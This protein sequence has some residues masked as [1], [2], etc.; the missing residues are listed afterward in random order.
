ME[1]FEKDPQAKEIKIDGKVYPL[2][3]VLARPA[4]VKPK[5]LARPD[6]DRIYSEFKYDA[7]EKTLYLKLLRKFINENKYVQ[8]EEIREIVE[9]AEWAVDKIRD[10]GELR[11]SEYEILRQLVTDYKF[12][13]AEK[14]WKEEN[15]KVLETTKFRVLK[16]LIARVVRFMNNPQK[17]GITGWRNRSHIMRYNAAYLALEKSARKEG[18]SVEA[19]AKRIQMI[20]R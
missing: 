2:S 20:T 4:N 16:N 18:E 14:K 9:D 7:Q 15:E 10:G 19:F 1:T 11:E 6:W 8:E 5:R 13:E 17:S 3:Q 12:S